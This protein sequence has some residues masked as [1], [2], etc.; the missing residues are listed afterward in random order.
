[1]SGRDHRPI[2]D[3]WILARPKVS[4]HGA[5]PSGFVEWA[6]EARAPA[7]P[8]SD[9]WTGPAGLVFL[10]GVTDLA[11]RVLI[12]AALLTPMVMIVGER[13]SHRWDGRPDTLLT[14]RSF[15]ML[16]RYLFPDVGDFSFRRYLA[17]CHLCNVLESPKRGHGDAQEAR[18]AARAIEELARAGGIR[19][20]LLGRVAA[21]AFGY[22]GFPLLWHDARHRVTLLPHP[23]GENRWWNDAAN[24]SAVEKLLAR[25]PILVPA[26]S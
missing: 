6:R 12:R 17:H 11:R 4:Y 21:E 22:Q 9:S 16:A 23:S 5:Y 7:G 14:G 10:H 1:M 24:S 2:C 13:P 8:D 26:Q 20:V 15:R 3:T 19:L 25:W 18:G